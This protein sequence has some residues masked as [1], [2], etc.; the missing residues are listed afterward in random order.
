M[1]MNGVWSGLAS[2][3]LVG[4]VAVGCGGN[5]T[6][7]GSDDA[8]MGGVSASGGTGGSGGT[9]TGGSGGTSAGGSGGTGGPPTPAAV[10]LS[11]SLSE[12]QQASIDADIGSRTCSAGATGAA[13]Y[14]LGKP[15]P[16]ETLADGTANVSVD[17]TVRADG[18]FSAE[19]SGYDSTTKERI[20]LNFSGRIDASSSAKPNAAFQFY[21]PQ[22][23]ALHTAA[24]F[25]DCTVGP[26]TTL[27][28]G[29]LLA[30]FSCPII[31]ASDDTTSGCAVHGTLALEYCKSG[32]EEL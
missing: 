26:V 20:A 22:T 19:V 21:S 8:G 30:D 6:H 28:V 24:P 14:T 32:E 29:A 1:F 2:G 23:L 12:P 9:G 11:I 15:A 31:I 17:C 27:R 7:D 4:V 5:S 18:S 10:G 16:G 13:T 25:P 3:V